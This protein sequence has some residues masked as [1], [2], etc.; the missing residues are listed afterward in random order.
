MDFVLVSGK[1]KIFSGGAVLKRNL[2]LLE[3]DLK[4]LQDRQ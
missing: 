4:P 1:L 2:F 3:S